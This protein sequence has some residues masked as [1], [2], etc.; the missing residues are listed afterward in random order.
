ML[1]YNTFDLIGFVVWTDIQSDL[2]L[3]TS[4]WTLDTPDTPDTLN[5][6]DTLDSLDTLNT[7]DT[8]HWDNLWESRG[9]SMVNG[10]PREFPE[11]TQCTP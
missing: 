11:I 5:T 1:L 10:A 6:L 3:E 9:G 2:M 7:A 4:F 8:R